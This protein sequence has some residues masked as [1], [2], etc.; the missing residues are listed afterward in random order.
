MKLGGVEMKI[1]VLDGHALNPGDNSWTELQRLGDLEVFDRSTPAEVSVRAKDADILLLNKVPLPSEMLER[2]PNLKLISVL[3]TGYNVVDVV[4]ARERGVVVSNVPD[5]GTNTVAQYVMAMLLELCHHVGRHARE[6]REG[7]WTSAPDWTFWSSPQVELFGKTMGIVGFGRIGRRV[8]QLAEAF[9][10]RVIYNSRRRY[11]D[12]VQEY[13]SIPELFAEAD[14]VSLHCG[15]TP[16]NAGMVNRDLLRQMKRSAFLV[17][18][19]RG[20]LIHEAD[21]AAALNEEKIAGAALDVLS[22][23]PPRDG[24]PLLTAKHCLVTPHMAWATL[25]ARKRIMQTTVDNVKSFLAGS[26]RNVVS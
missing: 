5:Y 12:V 26:P 20:G 25:E 6:V 10:M 17:N 18:T 9:G 2:L 15:L 14:V 3:A 11:D 1:V 24:N 7:A 4:A 8:G 22:F 23:E 21:L 19:A 16:E 13:R